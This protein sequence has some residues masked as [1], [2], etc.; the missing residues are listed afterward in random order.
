M[1]K[2]KTKILVLFG[3]RPEAIK[4]A[5]L[6]KAFKQN[7]DSFETKVC[8]TGQH[9]EMLDQVISFFD[10]AVDFDL[11]VMKPQQ[12]L[13]S[14]TATIINELK[15]IMDDFMPDYVFVH[16]DT[17]TTMAGSLAAFYS[18][19]KIAHIEAGLRTNNKL[20]PFPEEMNRQITTRLTDYHFAP[21]QESK[22]NLLKENIDLNKIIVTGNTVI[23]ALLDSV[24]KVNDHPSELSVSLN[25]TIGS[26]DLILVTGH[27]RENHGQGFLNICNALKQIAQ[28]KPDVIIIYPVH[29]NPNVQQPVNAILHDVPNI[30]LTEPKSYEDFIWLM[31]KAKIIITD[32]GGVQEEAP[33]LG[34]PVLVLR[35]TTERPE[36][37]H[38]GTVLL[39]GTDT[40]K[41]VSETIA[42]LDNQKK[43]DLMS[44]A[45]NPYGDGNACA[46]ILQFMKSLN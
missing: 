6:V 46:R 20:S 1:E 39:V 45:H 32:S 23:D 4:M 21:T 9:K 25:K 34:K 19:A 17:T 43:Y 16:G 38:A 7:N 42:L 41:I 26:R 15:P 18:G 5:P 22:E 33:S 3:T 44:K 29:L 12:N 28:L 8:I 11:K 27:R 13:H 30:L 40:L 35:E 36:A 31:N 24:Q 37:V 10:I 2:I 14:L